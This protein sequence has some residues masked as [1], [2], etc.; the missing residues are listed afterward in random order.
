MGTE[1]TIHPKLDLIFERTTT[2][3]PEK[4]WKAW[5]DPET[6]MK[7]FCP[8]PWKVSEARIDLKPGGEFYTL[9]QSPEG[10]TFPSMGCYLEV[11]PQKKLTWTN[12]M[13]AGF[14][15]AVLN[16]E[17]F[18]ITASLI[19]EQRGKETLYKAWV[20]HANEEGRKKHEAMHFE[21]GWGAAFNQLQELMK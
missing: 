17:D 9:M 11:I 13:T 6:L 20:T 3:S 4:I 21:E 14:R 10:Q 19:L 8:R 1:I 5:T 15:P 12:V 16:Q 18:A 7:W 2:M